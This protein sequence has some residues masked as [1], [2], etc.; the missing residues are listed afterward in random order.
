M[1]EPGYSTIFRR[2]LDFT[3]WAL[4]FLA[5]AGPCAIWALSFYLRTRTDLDVIFD[6]L[7]YEALVGALIGA[8][9][10]L[11]LRKYLF[12]KWWWAWGLLTWAGWLV[13]LVFLAFGAI[14]S[15]GVMMNPDTFDNSPI[16][17]CIWL[18][19]CGIAL[20]AAI[21]S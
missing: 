9:Q 6:T 7:Y 10:S 20:Q 8:L 21:L 12:A 14:F 19:A 16:L 18:F 13:A 11:V 5:T 17:Q 1:T 2:P 4:W 15:V 3:M